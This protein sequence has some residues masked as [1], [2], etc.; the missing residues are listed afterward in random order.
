[1]AQKE[2]VVLLHGMF[3]TKFHMRKM[4][5]YLEQQGYSVL[6]IGYSSRRHD[7][8]ALR[9]MIWHQIEERDSKSATLHFVGH[10]MGGLIIRALLTKYNP[11]HLG[12]VVLIATP[13]KGSELAD[14]LKSK[15]IYKKLAGPAGQQLVTDQ[16][17]IKHLFDSV[18]YE[19]G[20][21]AGDLSL[22][23]I[24]SLFIKGKDDGRVSVESTKLDGMKDHVTLRTTH[25]WLPT[26]KKAMRHVH[27]FLQR[28]FFMK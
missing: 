2:Y 19:C 18:A 8:A 11:P 1:M 25:A 4:A 16:E 26:N 14:F 12:R 9:D 3:R 17:S 6:N 23:P 15:W 20:V 28:G 21:I 27:H 7:I 24:S 10:S 5:H 13:N 22:E